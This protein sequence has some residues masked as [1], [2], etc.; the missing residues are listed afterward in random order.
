MKNP[1]S[2]HFSPTPLKSKG[3]FILRMN[4][5]KVQRLKGLHN[6]QNKT[7]YFYAWFR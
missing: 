3:V 6:I 1:D 2:S 5:T 4:G 7:E